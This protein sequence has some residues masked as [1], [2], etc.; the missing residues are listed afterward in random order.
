MDKRYGAA[1][2]VI[3]LV[4]VFV[5]LKI[6]VFDKNKSKTND[7]VSE[8]HHYIT[9]VDREHRNKVVDYCEKIKGKKVEDYPE[10][11]RESMKDIM[12][13][14]QEEVDDC[15]GEWTSSQ[16]EC[17]ENCAPVKKIYK[18]TKKGNILGKACEVE[19]GTIIYE[20]CRQENCSYDP[21]LHSILKNNV[22]FSNV[23]VSNTRECAT[24]CNE[25]SNC[26]V[27][28]ITRGNLCVFHSIPS[29]LKAI[30]FEYNSNVNSFVKKPTPLFVDTV[31][32][33][34]IPLD[35]I[36]NISVSNVSNTTTFTKLDGYDF[37][38]DSIDILSNVSIE[39]CKTQCRANPMCNL[40][41]ADK[42]GNVCYLKSVVN[43]NITI[44]KDPTRDVYH[45]EIN[46]SS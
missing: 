26:D 25:N 20:R 6:F 9:N 4:V 13:V 37:P 41:T 11:L 38:V 5:L 43:E 19:E 1:I 46:V 44:Y 42:D 7:E 10:H 17:S 12:K 18:F 32:D 28:S 8:I 40:F 33:A 36:M 45:A 23:Q 35:Q 21:K 14:C 30:D 34:I 22:G 2:F 16:E 15:Q 24:K 3:V 31:N 27:Y 29:G 39:E